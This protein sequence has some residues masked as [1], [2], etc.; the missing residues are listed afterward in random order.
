MIYIGNNYRRIGN[1]SKE[2]HTN[3]D[4]TEPCMPNSKFDLEGG[5]ECPALNTRESVLQ[6]ELDAPADRQPMHLEKT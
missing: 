1:S 2:M 6:P 4:N 5:Q 3:G